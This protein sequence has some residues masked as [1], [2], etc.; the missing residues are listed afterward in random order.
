M[1]I[2]KVTDYA[3]LKYGSSGRLRLIIRPLAPMDTS[4]L[5]F[6]QGICACAIS[7]ENSGLQIRVRTGKLL[8]LFLNQKICC[9]YSTEPSQ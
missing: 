3:A 1:K 4:V 2:S 6:K 7:T 5:S 9:G 8:V